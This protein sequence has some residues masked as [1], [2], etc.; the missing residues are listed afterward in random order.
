MKPMHL[1]EDGHY[2]FTL[3][4]RV[5][6]LNEYINFLGKYKHFWNLFCRKFKKQATV[7][8]YVTIICGRSYFRGETITYF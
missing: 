6:H 2:Y 4:Y 7:K 1:A 3:K 8:L 5:F